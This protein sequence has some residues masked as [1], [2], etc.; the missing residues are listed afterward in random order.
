MMADGSIPEHRLLII[1]PLTNAEPPRHETASDS[2]M[3]VMKAKSF[4]LREKNSC[5]TESTQFFQ[6]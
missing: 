3:K 4:S 6:A 5:A 1:L 2:V